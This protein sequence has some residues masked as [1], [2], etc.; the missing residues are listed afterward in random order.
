MAL[1]AFYPFSRDH[2]AINQVGASE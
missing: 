1:G 2:N